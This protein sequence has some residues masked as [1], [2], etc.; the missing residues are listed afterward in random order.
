MKGVFIYFLDLFVNVINLNV[1]EKIV[2]LMVKML[3]DKL[4]GLKV[5][6]ILFKFLSGIF[7]DVMRDFFEVSVYMFE[8]RYVE[9]ED[10]IIGV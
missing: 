8:G 10:K 2:E 9:Y 6:I 1:R 7:M 5:R 3:A 4:V